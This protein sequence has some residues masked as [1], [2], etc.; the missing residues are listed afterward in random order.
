MKRPKNE[1]VSVP[2][3]ALSKLVL[4]SATVHRKRKRGRGNI[5][6]VFLQHPV[7]MLPFETVDRHRPRARR[8]LVVACFPPK[9]AYDVVRIHRLGQV[10]AGAKLDCLDGRRDAAV[11]G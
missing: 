8:H 11:T 4:K 7:D 1:R 5:A 3:G 6:S 10:V 9:G 2:N